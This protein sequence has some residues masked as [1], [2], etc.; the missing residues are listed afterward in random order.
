VGDGNHTQT[1]NDRTTGCQGPQMRKPL[2]WLSHTSPGA[3]GISLSSADT[4]IA[5]C[6]AAFLTAFVVLTLQ[7]YKLYS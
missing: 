3:V 5:A 1:L 6:D 4:K 2:R 7:R